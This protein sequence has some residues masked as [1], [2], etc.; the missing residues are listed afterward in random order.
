[1]LHSFTQFKSISHFLSHLEENYAERT[2]FQWYDDEKE[3]IHKKNYK[4]FIADI[5]NATGRIAELSNYRQGAHIAIL[6]NNGYHYY[7]TFF[8]VMLT[9]GTVVPLN[10]K[11]S[12]DNLDYEI[13]YADVDFLITEQSFVENNP[14]VFIGKEKVTFYIERIVAEKCDS[15]YSNP[16]GL[17]ELAALMFTSGSTGKNKSIMISQR[18]IFSD[19]EYTHIMVQ[20]MEDALGRNVQSVLQILPMYHVAGMTALMGYLA[21]GKTLN[22]CMDT[23]YLMRDL[24]KM[25]AGMTMVVPVILESWAKLLRF[26]KQE[27][28]GGIQALA[29]GGAMVHPDI[30]ELFWEYGIAVIIVY[31]MTE[32]MGAGTYNIVSK[33]KKYNSIGKP[34]AGVM[35]QIQDGEICLKTDAVMLG[36]YKDDEATRE[37]VMDGW[38]HTGDIG[39]IDEEGFVYLTG[40]K[41]NLIILSSGE[42][43]SPEELEGL[44]SKNTNVKEVVV[45]EK[46]NKICAEIFCDEDKQEGI[47]S[48][49]TEVN[50]TLAMYKR[51]TLVEFRTEPF[52]RT[53]S[54]KIKRI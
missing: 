29:C 44:I 52:P 27:A 30:A 21:I 1:M 9:G 42:N 32:T 16:V 33:T 36:Y 4:E 22:I 26:G 43:V 51:M 2:A 14:D 45:K 41:K 39:H 11:E 5:K 46:N 10:I 53:S 6:A 3:V 37:V 18:N 15:F 35:V 17:D 38:M 13:N 49:V 20:E 40:R 31:A 25:G 7:V 34:G 54:G 50:R 19:L 28:L 47:R 48:F 23:R 12:A 24:E 8:G